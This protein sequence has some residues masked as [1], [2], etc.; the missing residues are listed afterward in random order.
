MSESYVRAK[1]ISM[2]VNKNSIPKQIREKLG[3]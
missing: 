1:S 3:I 2:L